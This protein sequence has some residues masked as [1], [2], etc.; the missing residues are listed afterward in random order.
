MAFG[1]GLDV[2]A[3]DHIGIRLIQ[4]EYLR[5]SFFFHVTKQRPHLGGCGVPFLS[6]A[7][8]NNR[9]GR[10][11]PAL[12]FQPNHIYCLA[13]DAPQALLW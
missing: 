6:I 7:T 3:T 2:N 1:G 12:L 9:A 5:T 11:R 10:K 13:I 8:V 4:V